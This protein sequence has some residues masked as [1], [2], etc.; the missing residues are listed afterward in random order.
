M[1][2]LLLLWF[3]LVSSCVMA[4]WC[5][6]QPAA[7]LNSTAD[8]FA[9]VWDR[10]R[11]CL[12]LT[13][14]RQGTARIY[15][16]EWLDSTWSVP[17]ELPGLARPGHHLS[18]AAPAPGGWLYLCSY[19]PGR[20][21]AYLT[22]A[23]VRP[24]GEDRWYWDDVPE[25][26][27]EESFTAHPTIAPDGSVLV[28]ASDRP[29]GKG[30]TDLWI[31]YRQEDGRW[32]KPENLSVLN[33]PGN[34]ITPFLASSDTLYFASD[35]HGG[36]GGYDLFL[37]VRRRDGQWQTPEPLVELNT[38]ADESDFCVLPFGDMALFARGR[39]GRDLDLIM[40]RRC[41][42]APWLLQGR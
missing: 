3:G 22:I 37:S 13:S 16:A 7:A 27:A 33:S 34:E 23:R 14:T 18:Y 36:A 28:F 10:E 32:G 11:R 35:G 30:G 39:R 19:R 2:G 40:A 6:T 15:C 29:G 8:D 20:R 31:C 38:E 17:R 5:E 4:Q 42:P 9:P 26:W 1:R 41:P 21:Q 12:L 25:L 24:Q